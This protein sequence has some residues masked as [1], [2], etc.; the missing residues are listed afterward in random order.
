MEPNQIRF[1]WITFSIIVVA[2]IG[3]G[4]FLGLTGEGVGALFFVL[5]ALTIA[6]FAF[7]HSRRIASR[8][9]QTLSISLFLTVVFFF[10][11]FMVF[12]YC[13]FGS[14]KITKHSSFC[15]VLRSLF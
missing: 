1:P 11:W 4:L 8:R 9:L 14:M 5:A 6:T 7:I 12:S 15:E 3:I 10:V 2:E 13:E